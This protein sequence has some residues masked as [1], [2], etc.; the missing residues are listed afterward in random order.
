MNL[1]IVVSLLTI[2]VLAAACLPAQKQVS[3]DALYD[4]VRRKLASDRDVKGGTLK[5]DVKGGVVTLSG[6]TESEKQKTRA[7][8]LT[9]GMRGVT[10]VVNQIHVLRPSK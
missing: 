8:K 5:V 10:K 6:D 1:K 4:L 2:F 7:E 3:D 9:R